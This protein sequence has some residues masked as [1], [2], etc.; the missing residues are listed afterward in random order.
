MSVVESAPATGALP[1]ASGG[2][3][4][5]TA[6]VGAYVALT[7]PRIIELLLVTTVPVMF[8]ASGGRPALWPVVATLVGGTLA[9]AS[10]NALNCYIDRDID[11]LMRRTRRRPLAAHT[12]SPR[13][14]VVFGVALGVAATVWLALL[15][16]P[17]SAGLALAANLFYVFVYSMVLKRRTAQNVVWGGLAG[18]FPTLIGWTAVTG[19]LAWP[20]VVLFLVVFL[21]TPPHTWALAMRYREDYAV[22]NVP[23]LPVV[24][25]ERVVVLQITRYCWATVVA[26]LLLWP[27]AG[28]GLVYPITAVVVGVALLAGAHRMVA[29]VQRGVSGVALAPMQLFHLSNVYLAILFAA[30]AID[31]LL[32]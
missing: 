15:V 28:T 23:M 14:A 24:A 3:R 10:A 27:V 19:E 11:E 7:K 20:P 13:G 6:K 29:A 31:P 22:A 8:L 21:W 9:A 16:N 17:I 26:S 12:V 32:T 18:C 25:S 2:A 1:A 4:A 5:A 30:V